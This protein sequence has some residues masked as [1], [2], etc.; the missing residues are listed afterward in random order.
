MAIGSPMR[1]IGIS[2][3]IGTGALPFPYGSVTI[4]KRYVLGGDQV[5]WHDLIRHKRLFA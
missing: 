4:S 1:A 5:V 2:L 3:E